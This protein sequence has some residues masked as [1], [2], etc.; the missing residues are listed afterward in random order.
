M[1][2]ILRLVCILSLTVSLI[3]CTSY[4]KPIHTD[5]LPDSENITK[6]L[7][8]QDGSLNFSFYGDYIFDKT[9]KRLI[10]FTN[11]EIGGILQHIKGKP[12]SQILF[13][14]TPA[15][16]YNNMFA[17]YYAGKTLDEIKKDFTTQHPEKEM[18]GGLLYRCQYNGHDIIEVYKQTEGGV[19]R[20][21]A[22]NDPGKQNTDKFKL[23]NDKLFF[24]LNAH[25]WTGL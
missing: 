16:I 9:D 11:K 2:R 17:F 8:F 24:E 25:L 19:V 10:F 7:S 20:W 3:S 18:P 21:I 23:E 15:S 12:S 1:K 13:T 5:P 4:I 6:K 22:I 14:Y